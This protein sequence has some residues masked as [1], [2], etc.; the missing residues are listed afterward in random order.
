LTIGAPCASYVTSAVLT[1][2]LRK[3]ETAAHG[4]LVH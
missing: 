1:S 3:I 2:A 4:T